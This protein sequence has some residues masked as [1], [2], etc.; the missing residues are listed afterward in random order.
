MRFSKR[1]EDTMESYIM[2]L[3]S[4]ANEPGMISLA[5]GLPDKRLFD[6]AGL[7]EAAKEV[8]EGDGARAALQYGVTEGL[9]ALREKIASRC[10]KEMHIKVSADN[11]FITNGSQE[12]FDHLGKI[13]LD[14]GDG[15]VVENPGYLGALQSYSVYSP[16]FVGVDLNENGPDMG[17]LTDALNTHPKIYYS[18]PNYQNPSGMSYSDDVRKEIAELMGDSDTVL[19][20]DDAYGELGFE[21][22]KRRSIRSMNEDVVLTGSFSK[23]ISPGMRVGWMIVPDEMKDAVRTSMEASCLHANS[24]SQ[25][26]M[27]RFLERND[28]SEYLR[29]IRAEYKRKR[30]LMLDLLDDS[31]M[32]ARWNVPE[33]GMFIWF[34]TPEGTDA[35]RLFDECLKR[36]LVIMP[37][38]PFHVRGGENTIRLNFATSSDEEIKTGVG[39]LGKAFSD[40]F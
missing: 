8:L 22:R 37:G 40:L 27:N 14:P 34:R 16:K 4:V 1:T 29:P 13:F 10:A 18:I 6:V 28:L 7:K 15:I 23:I 19:V 5:T 24:F 30:D 33:G 11:I 3:I 20:E 39:T 2:K 17:Q 26:V 35:M 32:D 31:G 38:R 21:G 9:P 12:C 36:K 25:A